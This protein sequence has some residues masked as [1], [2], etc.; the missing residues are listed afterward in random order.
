[1]EK[2][3]RYG[4]FATLNDEEASMVS[5]KLMHHQYYSQIAKD[6]NLPYST[7]RRRCIKSI[8]KFITAEINFNKKIGGVNHG[9]KN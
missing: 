1:M 4:T 3:E 8:K 9:I 6:F 7:A 5:R 2:I